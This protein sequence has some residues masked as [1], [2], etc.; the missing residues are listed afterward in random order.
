MSGDEDGAPI[1]LTMADAVKAAY[2]KK[3]ERQARDLNS[4]PDSPKEIDQA[5]EKKDGL[6][7]L[8]SP[9][10]SEP[11]TIDVTPSTDQDK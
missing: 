8:M 2:G 5:S 4:P 11:D 1:A 9:A 10:A 6:L 3:R 7:L